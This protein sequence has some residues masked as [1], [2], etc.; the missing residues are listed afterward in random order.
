MPFHCSRR[1]C[2]RAERAPVVPHTLGPDSAAGA[3]AQKPWRPMS[4]A[5]RGRTRRRDRRRAES[6]P[7]P[8]GLSQRPGYDGKEAVRKGHTVAQRVAVPRRSPA[9][10]G[11]SGSG[12]RT[13]AAVPPPRTMLRGRG[14]GE[15]DDAPPSRAAIED[16]VRLYLEELAKIPLLT[17]RD[18]VA[19]ARRAESGDADAR[20]RL[21]EANLRLVVSVARRY[22]GRGLP[23]L[24]LIQ[25]GNRGLLRATDKF[26]WRRGY[27]FATYATWW[28]RQSIIRALA[29]QSQV[30][31][32]PVSAGH[33]VAR[34][35]RISN[36]LT[37]RLGRA[38]TAPELART[39]GLSVRRVRQL[40]DLPKLVA[41]L[42]EPVGEDEDTAL[43]AMIANR[44]GPA[45][46][47]MVTISTLK[48]KVRALLGTLSP[49]ERRVLRLRFGLEGERPQTLEEVG[50]MFHVTRER[51]RQIEQE[52]LHKL[53][54]PAE[55]AQLQ[56]FVA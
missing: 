31:R 17:A 44:H 39:T 53:L 3:A 51:A 23:L 46:E 12:A 50:G 7:D 4:E 26:E 47:D 5:P 14:S 24:D 1:F 49:R 19:L 41:S 48:D 42:E 33:A 52:A 55:A 54:R 27:R 35:S 43:G 36:R 30:I 13:A 21:I 25:E 28:I 9:E 45:L 10:A 32:I 18:E 11:R 2:Y 29:N 8:M 37:D 16:P 6:G 40:L 22:A 15:N 34:L 56:D 20:Q 38:P